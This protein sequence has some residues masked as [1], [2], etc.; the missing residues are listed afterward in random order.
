MRELDGFQETILA[1]RRLEVFL[2]IHHFRVAQKLFYFRSFL[3]AVS[4]QFSDKQRQFFAVRLADLFIL[5]GHDLFKQLFGVISSEG[6]TKHSHFIQDASKRPDIAFEVVRLFVPHLG[7]GI[8]RRASLCD[9][10]LIN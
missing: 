1:F 9:C 3:L 5:S 8:V 4:H 6:G 7:R 2:H 10:K